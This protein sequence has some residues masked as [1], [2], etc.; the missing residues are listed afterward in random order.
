[1][2]GTRSYITCQSTGKEMLIGNTINLNPFLASCFHPARTKPV[3]PDNGTCQPAPACPFAY[4]HILSSENLCCVITTMYYS[5]SS[6]F[7]QYFRK[8]Y[9]PIVSHQPVSYQSSFL[10][11]LMCIMQHFFNGGR[12]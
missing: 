12:E 2:A 8:R 4:S 9:N 5:E 6:V 1:M 7:I 3:A 10:N 11:R